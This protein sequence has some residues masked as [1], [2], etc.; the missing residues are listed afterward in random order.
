M[1]KQGQYD[2]EYTIASTN[3]EELNQLVHNLN[4]VNRLRKESEDQLQ[5]KIG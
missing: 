1:A 3:D 5:K 2:F 4:Q